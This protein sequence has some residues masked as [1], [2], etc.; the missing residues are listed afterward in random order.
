MAQIKLKTKPRTTGATSTPAKAREPGAEKAASKKEIKRARRAEFLRR[1][2]K[3]GLAIEIGV[4]RGE[5]SRKI[6]DAIQPQTLCLIDP[7]KNFD[8]HDD[9]AFSGR[10]GDAKMD[11]IH[12]DVCRLYEAEIAS[13]QVR[14]MRQMSGDALKEFGD[15]TISFA[16]VDGDHSYEGIR[17]DLAALFP[18]M[19]E[20]GVMAFDDYHRRGWWGDA[21]LRAIHEFIGQHPAEVRVLRV[22]GAQIAIEKLEPLAG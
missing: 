15:R 12:A 13:G 8:D 19:V 10:E 3:G 2:P 9:K 6:L 5:F 7:W 4:W 18:K 14:V 22:I 16:Y 20:G 17:S 11:E 1:M 21:V